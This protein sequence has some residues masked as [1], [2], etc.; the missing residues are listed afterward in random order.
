MKKIIWFIIIIF[1]A[2]GKEEEAVKD[3]IE[4]KPVKTI[5]LQRKK[6][7]K[8][9]VGNSDILPLNKTTQI[10]KSGGELV[11]INYKNGDRVEKGELILKIYNELIYRGLISNKA[12]D[13][14]K[15]DYR[16]IC[17]KI[18]L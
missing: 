15:R 9:V 7:E 12:I 14:F 1:I 18:I 3:E 6:I 4:V 16:E 10:I 17:N 8:E 5:V 11:E 13:S 2:C